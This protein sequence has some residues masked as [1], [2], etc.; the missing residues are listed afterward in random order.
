[1]YYM[2]TKSN[3]RQQY[4]GNNP[5]TKQ[6]GRKGSWSHSEHELEHESAMGLC[7]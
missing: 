1:M 2:C 7:L 6:F 3:L 5:I 4:T